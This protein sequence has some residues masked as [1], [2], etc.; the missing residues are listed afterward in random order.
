MKR[1]L[2]FS[3]LF[4]LQGGM[5]N[6]LTSKLSCTSQKQNK[7]FMTKKKTEILRQVC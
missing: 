5:M 4:G 7:H 6:N 2:R 3:N 1:L